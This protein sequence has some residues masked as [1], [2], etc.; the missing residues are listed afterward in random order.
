MEPQD[1]SDVAYRS[2]RPF[3]VDHQGKRHEAAGNGTG[4][5]NL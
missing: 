1:L 2:P 3:A 4:E 5:N